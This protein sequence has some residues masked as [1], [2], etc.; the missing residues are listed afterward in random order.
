MG[1][2]TWKCLGGGRAAARQA[3]LPAA[4]RLQ[5]SCVLSW[6]RIPPHTPRTGC[7]SQIP[8]RLP[9][10]GAGPKSPRTHCA[11]GAGARQLP[12]RLPWV[13][14]VLHSQPVIAG[15]QKYPLRSTQGR[16]GMGN[17]QHVEL[18]ESFG[19]LLSV[20]RAPRE[21]PCTA[22]GECKGQELWRERW[23]HVLSTG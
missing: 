5:H 17:K 22:F 1:C 21:E 9:V 8:H 7:Q 15:Q 19:Q 14:P 3:L 6:S 16:L 13:S 20:G 18:W 11:L 23:Q 12:L 4:S 10:L 2:K